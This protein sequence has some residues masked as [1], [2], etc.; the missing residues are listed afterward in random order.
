MRLP[1]G[2]PIQ[3]FAHQ[4]LA[5]FLVILCSHKITKLLDRC[6]T[7]EIQF[8]NLYNVLTCTTMAPGHLVRMMD[9]RILKALSYG[10]LKAGWR[11]RDGQQNHYKDVL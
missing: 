10:Q 3:L 9:D 8:H 2:H 4:C 5:P 6:E 7:F 11:S 1:L